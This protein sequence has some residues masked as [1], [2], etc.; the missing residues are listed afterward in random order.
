MSV[1][2]NDIKCKYMFMF[3]LKKLARNELMEFCMQRV[4]LYPW[5]LLPTPP[6]H[7]SASAIIP[8]RSN[9]S[10][11]VCDT[12]TPVWRQISSGAAANIC[13]GFLYILQT[14][15]STNLPG[16]NCKKYIEGLMQKNIS[17][18]VKS[19]GNMVSEI[20]TRY[21]QFIHEGKL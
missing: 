21:P 16:R 9:I 3:P 12:N 6:H 19:G 17:N 5:K 4:Y 18:T 8:H 7:V 10:R 13:T 2:R 11:H 14:R 20:L 15:Q 1:W